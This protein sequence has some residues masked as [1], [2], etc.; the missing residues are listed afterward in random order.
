M[1]AETVPIAQQRLE[2]AGDLLAFARPRS[3]APQRNQARAQL[4]HQVLDAHQVLLGGVQ[5]A[6]GRVAFDLV[7]GDTGGLL[8]ER[9]PLFGRHAEGPVDEALADDRIGALAQARLREQIDDVLQTH[10]LAVDQVFVVAVAIGAAGDLH[11]GEVDGDVA[12]AVVQRQAHLGG[13]EA[14]ALV[15][16]GEDDVAGLL[17]AQQAEALLAQA[18]AHGVDDVALA[19][20]VGPDDGGDARIEEKL[21]AAGKGL[22]ALDDD[23]FDAHGAAS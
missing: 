15:A 22:E 10:P 11:L 3:L 13:V 23:A 20:A 2:V 14:G 4:R 12:R 7:A 21:G 9:P 6:D 18:P 17:R 16:A 19:A 1:P 5:A 8:E